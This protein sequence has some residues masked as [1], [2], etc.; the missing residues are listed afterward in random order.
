ML[1]YTSDAGWSTAESDSAYMHSY[2]SLIPTKYF[3]QQAAGQ[4]LP[5]Q[6]IVRD[7]AKGSKETHVR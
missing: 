4:I 7:E 5:G 6:V 3:V 1:V 2:C